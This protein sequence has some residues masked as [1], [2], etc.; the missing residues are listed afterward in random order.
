MESQI[1]HKHT[2][3]IVAIV[4][5]SVLAVGAGV[6]CFFLGQNIGYES[7]RISAKDE[8][9]Y[10]RY[11]EGLTKGRAERGTEL[12]ECQWKLEKYQK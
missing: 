9:Y 6:A 7:G 1:T 2:G 11:E 8:Y 3:F 4:C 5:L 10:S 12:L